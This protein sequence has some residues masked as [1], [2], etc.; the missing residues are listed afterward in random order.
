MSETAA[1]AARL[2]DAAPRRFTVLMVEDN[3][4]D[5]RLVRAQLADARSQWV[6]ESVDRLSAAVERLSRGG[7][8]VVLLDLSL[9]DSAR[10]ETVAKMCAHATDVPVVVLTGLGDDVVGRETLR[11]GA[12]DF[13]VKGRGG[14]PLLERVLRQ[15]VMDWAALRRLREATARLT[16]LTHEA[17]SSL[18][19]LPSGNPARLHLERLREGLEGLAGI[20]AGMLAELPRGR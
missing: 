20:V 18:S 1:T 10:A 13:L 11:M 2:G 17:E 14:A 12:Q 4:A 19:T 8:D 6:I 7:I 15:A 9:P 5:V 16:A 3:P